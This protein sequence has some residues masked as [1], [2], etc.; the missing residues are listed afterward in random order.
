MP[1]SSR[2]AKEEDKANFY[3]LMRVY[4]TASSQVKFIA[5]GEGNTAK[6]AIKQAVNEL[7]RNL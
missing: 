1:F 3:F 2:Y 7:S 5:C 6:S 4:Q